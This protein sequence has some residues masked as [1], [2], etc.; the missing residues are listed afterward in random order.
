MK[1]EKKDVYITFLDVTKAYDKAW[2]KAIIYSLHKS[3]IKGKLL[4]IVNNMN[5]DL[6]ARIQS[7]YGTIGSFHVKSPNALNG[8]DPDFDENAYIWSL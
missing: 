3:G 8:S 4:R 2:M 6:T 7:K 5:Q 1:K